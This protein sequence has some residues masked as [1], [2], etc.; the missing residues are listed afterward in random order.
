MHVLVPGEIFQ[1]QWRKREGSTGVAD[2]AVAAD[3]VSHRFTGIKAYKDM[4][5]G[6]A[7][8]RLRLK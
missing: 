7:F 8:L 3:V 5:H 6:L 2:Q 1:G 4:H